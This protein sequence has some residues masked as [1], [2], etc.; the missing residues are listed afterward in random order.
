MGEN[1]E[2]SGDNGQ[3]PPH[4]HILRD[5]RV[6]LT[7]QGEGK[8]V[9]RAPVV[10]EIRAP[11]GSVQVGAVATMIDVLA[12]ALTFRAVYPDWIATASLS[13]HLARRP[14]CETLVAAG[15]VI[16]SGR[17][18][19]IIDVDIRE[20]GSGADGSAPS[21]G[22]GMTTFSR[23]P[24]RDDTPVFEPALEANE[25]VDFGIDGSGLKR[26]YRDAA[27]IR[28]LDPG[29]GVVELELKAYVRNSLRVLQG[30]MIGVLADTAGELAAGAAL[31]KGM[32]TKDLAIQYLSQGK[33]GPFRT[34]TRMI[35]RTGNTSLTR[36]DVI[37]RG[38]EDRV[39]AV[40]MNTSIAA[41]EG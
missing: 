1:R 17:T 20:E 21:I 25:T 39:I 7:F 6:C 12:G 31:G 19:A 34:R 29:A 14:V 9:V 36:V 10:P 38:L 15:E 13:V 35:R 37:D 3:Y 40:V 22:T 26:P 23:L 5:L 27:G 41:A 30:G 11:D 2:E 24:R 33:K 8:A 28:V 4:N 16:R 18:M 32:I